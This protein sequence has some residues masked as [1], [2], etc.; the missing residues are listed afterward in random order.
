M[1]HNFS[2][3]LAIIRPVTRKLKRNFKT[4]NVCEISCLLSVLIFL[5]NSLIIG[6]KTASSNRNMYS[7]LPRIVSCV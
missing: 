3:E 1:G 2:F 5:I 4:A 6:L 7:G